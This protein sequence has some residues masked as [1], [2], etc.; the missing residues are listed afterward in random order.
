MNGKA[1]FFMW[2]GAIY[3][4][5]LFG[6][7][8]AIIVST[9]TLPDT[10]TFYI[11]AAATFLPGIGWWL[12]EALFEYWQKRRDKKLLASLRSGIKRKP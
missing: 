1:K 6:L 7:M 9:G 10:A 12:A 8:G 4:V 5:L 2:K 11:F 3:A